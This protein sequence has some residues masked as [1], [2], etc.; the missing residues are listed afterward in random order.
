MSRLEVRAQW[1]DEAQ[2]WWAK[3]DDIPGLVTEAKTF[4][5]LADN[6]RALTPDLLGL[7]A[8]HMDPK[9][10]IH[11]IAERVYA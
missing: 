1:D 4:E 8:P 6:I 9:T 11:I 10:P 2:V 5:E 7:N 3:S